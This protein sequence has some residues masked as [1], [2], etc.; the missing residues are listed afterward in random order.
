MEREQRLPTCRG[1]HF[2]HETSRAAL[3][4]SCRDQGLAAFRVTDT[5]VP[6]GSR[7]HVRPADGNGAGLD[8]SH[9]AAMAPLLA[10]R[11]GIQN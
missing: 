6:P 5:A 11:V 7:P 1:N 9:P 8:V 2:C 3:G 4:S 10:V